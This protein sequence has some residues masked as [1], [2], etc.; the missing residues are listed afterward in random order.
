[1]ATPE[2]EDALL[3]SRS[4]F[5]CP[6]CDECFEDN[7]SLVSHITHNIRCHKRACE[8]RHD[9]GEV[10]IPGAR[11]PSEDGALSPSPSLVPDVVNDLDAH[12]DAWAPQAVALGGYFEEG[13]LQQPGGRAESNC[14]EE[15][16]WSDPG[17]YSR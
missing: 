12:Y 6:Y 2:P 7:R 16:L 11:A 14:E 5:T 13:E 1:M 3:L 15:D 8:D 4:S 9:A 10:E 17:R